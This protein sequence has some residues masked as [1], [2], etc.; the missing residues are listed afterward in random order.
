MNQNTLNKYSLLPL[1]IEEQLTINGG[2]LWDDVVS[3]AKTVSLYTNAV[4]Y[5]F[6]RSNENLVNAFEDGFSSGVNQALK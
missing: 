4:V 5:V 2:N 6:K 3:T 1:S